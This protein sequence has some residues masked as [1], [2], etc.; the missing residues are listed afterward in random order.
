MPLSAAWV[1]VSHALQLQQFL[2]SEMHCLE[3]L[4]SYGERRGGAPL[5]AA[6]VRVVHALQLQQ[7]L[8]VGAAPPGGAV[9]IGGGRGAPLSAAWVR[10]SHALQLQHFLQSEMRCLAGLRSWGD[11]RGG[12]RRSLLRG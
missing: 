8:Q 12:K 1:R 3:G 7:L 4:W 5:S 9:V 6:W 11:G 2:Q 10:V